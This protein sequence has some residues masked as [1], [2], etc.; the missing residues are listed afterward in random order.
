M[1]TNI[2]IKNKET[3]KTFSTILTYIISAP[4]QPQ[5]NPKSKTEN[6]RRENQKPVIWILV[7]IWWE[8]ITKKPPLL[9]TNTLHVGD[10]CVYCHVPKPPFCFS[11]TIIKAINRTILTLHFH[12]LFFSLT[13]SL[14]FF[15]PY[16]IGFTCSSSSDF[17]LSHELLLWSFVRSYISVFSHLCGSLFCSLWRVLWWKAVWVRPPGVFW[18]VPMSKLFGFSGKFPFFFFFNH[19]F[20]S[21]FMFLSWICMWVLFQSSDFHVV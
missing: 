12:F 9:C 14:F 16:L 10:P 8:N 7:L 2:E 17:S 11:L 4:K 5:L 6:H 21:K 19:G 1:I 15:L 20:L 13:L 18:A 3:N